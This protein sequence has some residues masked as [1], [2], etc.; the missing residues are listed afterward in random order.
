[1]T[2][3]RADRLPSLCADLLVER[4]PDI[5][6]GGS[7]FGIYSSVESRKDGGRTWWAHFEFTR[8]NIELTIL[9]KKIE[10]LLVC[11]TQPTNKGYSPI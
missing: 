2:S 5:D 11:S 4:G 1:M 10:E 7:P 6:T 8:I 3:G 9:F